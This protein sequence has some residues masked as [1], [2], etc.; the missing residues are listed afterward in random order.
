M[1]WMIPFMGWF[2]VAVG[3]LKVLDWKRFTENF[4]KYDLIAM[5]SKT[6]S[7]L[8]P[9]IEIKKGFLSTGVREIG[10]AHV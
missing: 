1:E 10:R 9:L 6:Y 7:N 3:I 4:M 2:L 8:Y 5:R